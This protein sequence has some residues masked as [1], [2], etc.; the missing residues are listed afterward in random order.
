[1]WFCRRKDT[2][3]AIYILRTVAER[4]M[5]YKKNLYVCFIDY[6][7]AVDTVT[8]HLELKKSLQALNVDG[9]DLRIIKKLYWK[10]TVKQQQFV[11]RMN[12]ATLYFGWGGGVTSRCNVGHHTVSEAFWRP[13]MVFFI[14]KAELAIKELPAWGF[15]RLSP[16]FGPVTFV[17]FIGD[18]QNY[19]FLKSFGHA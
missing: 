10:Q 1:M 18:L 2:A 6:T 5:K 17:L 14:A 3:N 16:P 7:N 15:Y 4:A 19:I 13:S 9:K 11:V 12:L 8:R